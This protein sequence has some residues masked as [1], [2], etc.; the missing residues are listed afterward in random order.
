MPLFLL[1][2]LGS[3]LLGDVA[4]W[5]WG[6]RKLR[7]TRR[8]R[9]WRPLLGLWAG[10]LLGYLLWFVLLPEQARQAHAWMPAFVLAAMYI[11]HLLILP[12]TLLYI[13]V[14]STV[15]GV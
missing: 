14:T 5:A 3:M 6:D 10:V 12:P 8:A 15:G 7:R 2:I 11:W 13:I 9:V 1:I 4:F